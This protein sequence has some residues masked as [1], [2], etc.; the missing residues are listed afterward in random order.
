MNNDYK[1]YVP[2]LY[3]VSDFP[4]VEDEYYCPLPKVNFGHKLIQLV[5]P[6]DFES[7]GLTRLIV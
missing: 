1:K 3:K 5:I 6:K 2:D 7:T 4:H